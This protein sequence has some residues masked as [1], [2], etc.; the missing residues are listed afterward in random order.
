MSIDYIAKTLL[1]CDDC[2]EFGHEWAGH[3]SKITVLEWAQK[4]G[5]RSNFITGQ[6]CPSC[7]QYRKEHKGK[8]LRSA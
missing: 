2:G 5:W 3:V 4:H 6:I 7:Y 1:F 8:S